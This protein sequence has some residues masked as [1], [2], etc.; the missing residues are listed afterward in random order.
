MI[1]DI[2]SEIVSSLKDEIIFLKNKLSGRE[3][4][5]RELEIKAAESRE[6]YRTVASR[7]RSQV[8]TI[9]NLR[10]QVEDGI[11]MFNR[12]SELTA[13]LRSELKALQDHAR[14]PVAGSLSIVNKKSGHGFPGVIV[15]KFLTTDGKPRIVVESNVPEILGMLQ[16]FNPEQ[17]KEA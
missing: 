2:E 3:E 13:N 5:I 11:A 6:A 12:M 8:N 14:L 4:T 7:D 17:I 9:V 10:V 16:I 1:G 15:A